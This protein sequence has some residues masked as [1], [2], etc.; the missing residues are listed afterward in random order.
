MKSAFITGAATGIGEALAV[1]LQR[2]GW[3]VFT[4]YRSSPPGNARW[5]GQPN[6][7]AVQCD[8]T[9][10]EDVRAAAR[11]VEAATGGTLD[12][13]VNNAGYS[14]H[15]G[16]IE[17]A[18]M[19]EYRRAYEVNLWGPLNVIQAM[20]PLLR[21]S[22]GRIVNTGSASVYMTV[23]M[24]SAYPSSKMAL[25]VVSQH[26]RMELAPFGIQVTTLEPGGVDTAMVDLS[27][28]AEERQWETIP[29]ELRE[30]YRRHFVSGATAIGDNFTFIPPDAFA[31]LVWKRVISAKR[32]KP[33]YLI[34]PKVTAL[35]WMHR[36][37]PARQVE[38]IWRRMFGRKD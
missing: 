18:D 16:V 20:A 30:H 12:L 14:P 5:C 15:E 24:Y 36:L 22:R 1:R 35:P 37:L 3:L 17:A 9:D 38:K 7:V 26:L 34:G 23:P 33:S 6:I 25:K 28:E 11:T 29:A 8:V 27:P 32:L 10:L 4:G 2:E 13:L 19:A 21:K 31:D